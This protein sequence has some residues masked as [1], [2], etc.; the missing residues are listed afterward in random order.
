VTEAAATLYRADVD[1]L[2]AVA[3]ILVVVYHAGWHPFGGGFVGVDVFFVISGFLITGLLADELRR[4][5]TVSL[6]R[7]SGRRA[8][9]LLPLSTL[10]LGVTA[11]TFLLLLS[12]LYRGALAGDVRAAALY[13]GNWHFAAGALLYGTISADSPVIH[14]WSL[15][16]EEQFYLLWPLL[17]LVTAGAVGRSGNCRDWPRTLGDD[18]RGRRV[19]RAERRLAPPRGGSGPALDPV[20]DHAATVTCPG[21]AVLSAAAVVASVV[22]LPASDGGVS[23]RSSPTSPSALRRTSLRARLRCGCHRGRRAPTGRLA[24][25]T[26]TTATRTAPSLPT[27]GSA[28]R[29]RREASL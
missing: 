29:R 10:V 27:A 23:G 14:Y 24:Y 26:A 3:V 16:F 4:D 7:F 20:A 28:T 25:G 12:P 6:A 1:G 11:T 21:R 17:L 19:L 15:G 13:V 8:R 18:R 9:R 2:R 5:G 22:I